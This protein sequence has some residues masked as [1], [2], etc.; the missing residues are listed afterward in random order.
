MQTSQNGRPACELQVGQHLDDV[1]SVGERYQYRI[2][3][4]EIEFKSPPH[5]CRPSDRERKRLTAGQ[6]TTLY[7]IRV[8]M[9]ILMPPPAQL[10]LVRRVR[11][12]I[13]SG[14]QP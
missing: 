9:S 5:D 1:N 4:V 14:M 11:T 13:G 7:A 6:R 3:A 2:G 10:P 12:L 8:L